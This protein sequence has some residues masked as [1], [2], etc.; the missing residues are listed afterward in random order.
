LAVESLLSSVN[1]ARGALGK[2]M[3]TVKSTSKRHK[4]LQTPLHYREQEKVHAHTLSTHK[5]VHRLR[6]PLPT[7]LVGAI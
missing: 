6:A 4:V 7:R 5:N 2:L 3:K 1:T